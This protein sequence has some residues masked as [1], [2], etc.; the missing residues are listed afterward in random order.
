MAAGLPADEAQA[1]LAPVAPDRA[2]HDGASAKLYGQPMWAM[3]ADLYIPPQALRLF[4]DAFEGPLDLLLYLIRKQ[5]FNI[6]DIPL[7]ALT[8]QYLVY[9]EEIRNQHLELAADYLLMAATL[10]EIKSRLLL[11]SRKLAPEQEPPDPRA[12]LV[13]RLLQYE[14][15]KLAAQ[16]LDQLPQHGRDF[17]VAQVHIDRPAAPPLPTVRPGQLRA[18]WADILRRASLVQSHLIKRQPLSVRQHMSLVLRQ[19]QSQK[20]IEF[21][22]LFQ[23]HDS[24]PVRVVTFIALLELAKETLIELTQAQAYAPLYVRLAYSTSSTLAAH[25]PPY[26]HEHTLS[27]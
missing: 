27:I 15:I 14:Q 17:L 7:A 3:P 4:L 12:E 9:V 11:P 8:R 16:Q 2:A 22:E 13:R 19:L 10:I 24:L 23:P 20:F 1:H 6:L 18:A 25:P 26:P 5:H 21:A